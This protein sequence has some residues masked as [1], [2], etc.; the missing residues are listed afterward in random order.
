MVITASGFEDQPHRHT[1]AYSTSATSARLVLLFAVARFLLAAFSKEDSE[2]KR[3]DEQRQPGAHHKSD[4]PVI[5][6]HR[7]DVHQA[8][9]RDV[10][11][12]DGPHPRS[13]W[14]HRALLRAQSEDVLD[15][16]CN[17][18]QAVVGGKKASRARERRIQGSVKPDGARQKPGPRA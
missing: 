10:K 6:P 11:D 15:R 14:P 5:Y 8:L 16:K 1:N 9:D 4:P 3:E 7:G 13:R 17:E 12:R 18:K 2:P